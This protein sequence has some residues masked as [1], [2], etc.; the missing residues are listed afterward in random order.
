MWMLTAHRKSASSTASLTS[1]LGR[2]ESNERTTATNGTGRTAERP[3]GS[4]W[5]LEKKVWSRPWICCTATCMSCMYFDV[6]IY[7]HICASRALRLAMYCIVFSCDKSEKLTCCAV[8]LYKYIY[9]FFGCSTALHRLISGASLPE[10]TMS[11]STVTR[12][13]R[14]RTV[15]V[16]LFL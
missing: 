12:A 16:C 10:I 15:N 3:Q 8:N 9:T 2:G 6:Y 11:C 1:P 13:S 7:I 4:S 14:M 5:S